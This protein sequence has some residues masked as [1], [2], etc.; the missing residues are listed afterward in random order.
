[1]SLEASAAAQGHG[2][3][4]CRSSAATAGSE[5]EEQAAWLQGLKEYVLDMPPGSP[6]K[7]QEGSGVSG[8]APQATMAACYTTI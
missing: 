3:G 6:E 2:G 4:G 1:M 5:L 7:E 8:E